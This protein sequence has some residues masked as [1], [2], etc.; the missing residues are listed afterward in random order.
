M[1]KATLKQSLLSTCIFVLFPIGFYFFFFCLLTFPLISKF[2]THFFTHLNLDGLQNVWNIWWVNK[3]VTD[4]HQLPWHT[5]YLHYPYGISL[6]GHTLNP[7][8]GFVGIFLLKLFTLV[9][10]YNLLVVF[11]FVTGG[12]FTFF[13]TYYFSKSYWGSII[14]G[15]IFTFSNYHFIHMAVGH[16]QLIALEWIPLFILCAYIFITRPRIANAVI[17]AILLFLVV[18]CDYYYFFYCS[19]IFIFMVIWY[20][21]RQRSLFFLKKNCVVAFATFVFVA[22]LTSGILIISLL[23]LN[24]K[25]PLLGSHQSWI[26][27]T[28]LFSPFIHGAFWRFGDLTK[29]FWSRLQCYYGEC[30]VHLGIS[31]IFVLI[32][33]W[34]KRKKLDN[35]SLRF[36]YFIMI[37]FFIMSLG[38]FLRVF[39]QPMPFLK[40]PYEVLCILLPPLRLSGVPARMMIMVFLSAAVIF[41]IGFKILFEQSKYRRWLIVLLILMIFLEYLPRPIPK[42]KISTP[43]YIKILKELPGKDCVFDMVNNSAFALYLQTIYEKPMAF[44]YVSR[45]P[46]SINEKDD[47]LTQVIINQD[48]DSLY[49]DYNIRYLIVP[50]LLNVRSDQLFIK[51]LYQDESVRLY[52]IGAES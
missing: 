2:S 4:L 21:I 10:T 11:S 36:W 29:S 46:K 9:E 28:D 33:V 32:Y 42:A 43:K 44:G 1:N 47:K 14:S 25:D 12:L 37:F 17:C 27:A 52:D 26:F 3:A 23:L 7:F 15:F 30:S 16:M 35:P 24:N 50:I 45:I 6:L 41:A 34:I 18:L 22:L 19:L 5:N 48:Y 20:S 49:Y 13:L 38:P 8:N 40:M 31:I 39:G 51:L